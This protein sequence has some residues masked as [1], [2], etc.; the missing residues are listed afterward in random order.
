MWC[1]FWSTLY[2]SPGKHADEVQKK[3]RNLESK[4]V[5]NEVDVEELEKLLYE[6]KTMYS[7]SEK[8]LDENT[9]RLGIMENEL[10]RA[11]ERA[12]ASDKRLKEV[13]QELKAVGENMKAL[14]VTEEKALAREEKYK[15]QIYTLV[16]RLKTAESRIEYGDMNI[17]KLNHRIDDIEDDIVREKLKIEK[18]CRELDETFEDMFTKY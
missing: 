17:T 16:Q 2:L 14:E 13:E 10:K 18:I 6:A 12:A 4:C 11:Q 9:R 3:T 1:D 5:N 15:D 8:K 7:D